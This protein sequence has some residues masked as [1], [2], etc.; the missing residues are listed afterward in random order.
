MFGSSEKGRKHKKSPQ[1]VENEVAAIFLVP[2]AR[3]ERSE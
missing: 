1:P 2:N 3:S